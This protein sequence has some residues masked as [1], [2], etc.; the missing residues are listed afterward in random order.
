MS[1]HLTIEKHPVLHESSDYYL[2]RQKGLEF[3]TQLGSRWWTDH[4][5]H[6]PGITILEA[7]CYSI[8]ELAH[9]TGSDIKDLLAT[10]DG[11]PFDPARQAFFTA[12]EILTVNPWTVNDF[13][14]LLID[15]EGIKNA[16]LVCKKCPCE[17]RLYVDCKKSILTYEKPKPPEIAADHEVFAKGLYDILLEFDDDGKFGDMNSGKIQ[18]QF[19]VQL[20]ETRELIY[21]E[22]RMLSWNEL[23]KKFGTGTAAQRKL[24]KD[25]CSDNSALKSV[26]VTSIS[27]NKQDN[28]DIAND[29]LATALRKPMYAT[30]EV[31]YELSGV[32]VAEPV[33][34]EDVP[35]NLVL[36]PDSV[37]KQLTV[38]Q[39]R[40]ELE[41][42]SASGIMQRYLDKIKN[43]KAVV[44]AT[45][46]ELHAHRN[47]AEDFCRIE[48]VEIEEI[49]ICADMEV[50]AESDIEKILAEAYYLISE[51]FAPEIKFYSLEELML[52]GKPVDEIFEGPALDHGFID[53]TELEKAA[54]KKI[55]YTSDIIN[56]LMDIPGVKAI[57]NLVLVRYNKEG[58]AVESQPWKL[59]MKPNHQPRLFM[60][61]SKFLVF[62]NNLPFLPDVS[63]LLDTLQVVSGSQQHPK[64][65][66]HE[67]DLDV[68]K[69]KYQD[70][71]EYHPIQYSFPL[72]YGVGFEGLP[73]DASDLRRAQ[74]RQLKAYLMFFEQLL[75]NYLAQLSHVGDL[76]AL[77]TTIGDSYFTNLITNTTIRDVET[78]LYNGLAPALNGLVE[79]DTQF[80]DRRNRFLDHLLARFA[81]E[82]SDYAIMLY[83]SNEKNVADEI[84]IKDKIAFL[85]QYPAISGNRAKAFNYKDEGGV[86][87]S[88]NVAGLSIRISA[89]LGYEQYINYFGFSGS[90]PSP[91]FILSSSDKKVLLESTA[92]FR[93]AD[94]TP[95]SPAFRTAATAMLKAMNNK[96]SYDIKRSTGLKF[97][98]S[99]LDKSG[100]TLAFHPTLFRTKAEA[101]LQR[102]AILEFAGKSLKQEKFHIVEH[103]L[104][105]PRSTPGAQVPLGD[106]LLPICVAPDCKFCGDED[107]YS[108]RLTFVMNGESGNAKDNIAFRR[109]AEDTIRREV[110]AHLTTKVC[111]VREDQFISFNEAYCAWLKELAKEEP[112]PQ[113]L[114]D[115]LKDVIDIFSELR[116]VYPPASLHDCVDGNDENRVYLDQTIMGKTS[117]K[118]E[119]HNRLHVLEVTG[120]LESTK[121]RMFTQWEAY[122]KDTPFENMA[123]LEGYQV[124]FLDLFTQRLDE[125]KLKAKVSLYKKIQDLYAE[126]NDD[127]FK[128]LEVDTG[129]TW[130]KLMLPAGDDGQDWF[131]EYKI[132]AGAGIFNVDFKEW[133]VEK[134]VLI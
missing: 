121:N 116:S 105:R 7:L 101:E 126:T 35:F 43:T 102:D 5:L 100:N 4:N 6:D 29:K 3:I 90:G 49:A 88:N 16:W 10:P 52:A 21:L 51:Y 63:E 59:E 114:A 76:F 115:R 110:P 132:N 27:G 128:D 113:T 85:K 38:A 2:L 87:S 42:T 70:W 127:I 130:F 28:V 33:I 82:F 48:A 60:E 11:T 108:F 1:A 53:T 77:D 24:W 9:R 67:L 78:D 124:A 123:S 36:V 75:V 94:S 74:A 30:M 119:V 50:K 131:M 134:T 106:P 71:A 12:R 62:K 66:D 31:T 83:S 57:K 80:L 56:L 99:L 111:W 73:S 58:K 112:N 97:K 95:E 32:P 129:L 125:L 93:Q 79:T 47:L 41:N 25:L 17:T 109:F 37:R 20:A 69:G 13:R 92:V 133:F 40:T 91:K 65:K 45:K 64:L 18:H 117:F 118:I 8:T 61:A 89:L 98:L 44:K 22:V 104:M 86:C 15:I 107:P 55:L 81:E 120:S 19:T 68:P 39:L 72:T 14:K 26:K 84:L 122:L 103:L 96:D 23:T 54:L 46:Q 34:F